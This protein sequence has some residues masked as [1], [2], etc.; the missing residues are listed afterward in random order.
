MV[1]PRRVE[2]RQTGIEPGPSRSRRIFVFLNA[3]DE[4]V[5]F[6]K[7][8]G[9]PVLMSLHRVKCPE[10]AQTWHHG[11][12]HVFAPELE[13]VEVFYFPQ[14]TPVE[15]GPTELVPGTHFRMTVVDANQ[16]GPSCGY[17]DRGEYRPNRL[18][19]NQDGHVRRK[20]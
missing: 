3:D 4:L 13:F 15:M 14:N 6:A 16:I 1:F 19:G 12:D 5:R 18:K 20:K 7:S 2:S 11:A 8:V 17:C 9:F 10:S